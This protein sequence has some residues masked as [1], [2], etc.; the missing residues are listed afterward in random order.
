V[1]LSVAVI[2][3]LYFLPTKP[4]LRTLVMKVG[5]LL[6]TG[7]GSGVGTGVE[8]PRAGVG[9]GRT[10][11]VGVGIGYLVDIG[12]GVGVSVTLGMTPRLNG[13]KIHPSKFISAGG[14]TKPVCQVANP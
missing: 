5:V 1:S 4:I 9:L 11:T 3:L 14:G 13:N 12:V 2:V 7:V 10:L 6:T 8:V